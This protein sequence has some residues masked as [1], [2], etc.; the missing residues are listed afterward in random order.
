VIYQYAP[1]KLI[2]RM[3]STMRRFEQM[4]DS[5]I[6]DDIEFCSA[7]TPVSNPAVLL[8]KR[9]RRNSLNAFA[10]SLL[11]FLSACVQKIEVA[12]EE[13]NLLETDRAFARCSVDSGAAGAFRRYL[14]TDALMLPAGGLPISGRETIF[15]LMKVGDGKYV[16][17]WVPREAHVAKSGDLG[18]T[19]GTYTREAV[20][21]PDSVS[22]TFGKYLNIWTKQADG[23][24]KV[25]VDMGN[26]SPEEQGG[27]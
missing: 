12:A 18:W 25:R 13:Q 21:G 1:D 14:T 7:D 22:K 26:K 19:W 24:W 2:F 6:I 9:G 8:R 27:I 23:S 15:G 20:L 5:D 10:V 4:S 3:Q 17:K 11:I 16:L